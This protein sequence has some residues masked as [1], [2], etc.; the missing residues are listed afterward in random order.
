MRALGV[1]VSLR[2]TGLCLLPANWYTRGQADWSV[3]KTVTIGY[4][5]AQD[6][7][8]NTRADRLLHIAGAVKLFA[9]R[10]DADHATLEQYAFSKQHANMRAIAEVTG[11]IKA[12]LHAEQLTLHTATSN[13]VRSRLLGYVPKGKQV[14]KPV[15]Q[16]LRDLRAPFAELPDE[17]DAFAL[18][19][20]FLGERGFC[21]VGMAA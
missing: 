7:D 18:A 20:W 11:C 13:E 15:Q 16:F 10:Y 8:E 12:G 9:R 21:F 5:L 1:D 17:C 3:V 14:K 19:N 4:G 6:A 2:G